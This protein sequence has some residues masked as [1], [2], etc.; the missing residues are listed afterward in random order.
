MAAHVDEHFCTSWHCLDDSLADVRAAAGFWSPRSAKGCLDHE[1]RLRREK[2]PSRFSLHG[3][4]GVI[5]GDARGDD[6]GSRGR[7]HRSVVAAFAFT[8]DQGTYVT[9]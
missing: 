6:R 7:E 2:S 3:D 9:N 5:G 8:E 4:V 1:A